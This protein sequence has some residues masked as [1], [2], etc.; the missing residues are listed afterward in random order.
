MSDYTC[1]KTEISNGVAHIIMSRGNELNTMT[2]L[3]WKELPEII[4]TID[5]NA[6]ARVILLRGEGKHFSAG[7][8]LANFVNDSSGKKK[9]DPSR[10]REAFYHELLEL[11]GA[12]TALEKCRMPTIA[13]IQGACV[14]GAID[15]AAACDMRYCS[16][17]AFY[18][19]AEVDIGIA[20][21]VGTLQRL[22][23]LMP[24]GAVRELAYTGRK[25]DSAEA[26]QL[27]FVEKVFQDHDQLLEE[28]TKLAEEIASKSPLVTSV[29]KK[30]INYA[31][32]NS[33][34]DALD[35]HAIWNS[36]LISSSDMESAMKAYMEKVSGDFED[37]EPKKSF[38][39]KQGLIS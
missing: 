19:I 22:P 4:K 34:D 1:F 37:L 5:K 13:A 38:W 3:F 31:R 8:D 18:K 29:I 2:R 36:A 11:Q 14:G 21:D 12:F 28:T 15:M 32:D 30:Q 39:E 6:D 35:Y 17:D 16:T 9:K 20:A 33:V 10:T 26:Q 24:L 25:F 23:T 7:M 27:G